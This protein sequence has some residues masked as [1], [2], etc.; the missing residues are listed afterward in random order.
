[1]GQFNQRP[2]LISSQAS[3]LFNG[4]KF[5]I[6]LDIN[7]KSRLEGMFFEC[8][9]DHIYF[10]YF[11]SLAEKLERCPLNK[12]EEKLTQ[13]LGEH[14]SFF[15]TQFLNLPNFLLMRAFSEYTG[16]DFNIESLAG[17]V[18]DKLICRCFG[19]FESQ[20]RDYVLA[21]ESASVLDIADNLKATIG[22]GSCMDDVGEVLLRVKNQGSLASGESRLD[23]EFNSDGTRIMPM[24]LNP[25]DF[26]LKIDELKRM[27]IKEQELQR[28]QLE[29]VGIKGHNI[30]FNIEPQDNRDYILQTFKEYVESKLNL[31]LRFD[32]T[33]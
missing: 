10:P 20:I 2:F 9:S 31:S 1:M 25:S 22:C 3:T 4:E 11:N 21:N 7:N 19:V 8:P 13:W 33:V 6:F 24:G 17:D 15:K 5:C 32:F 28:Y 29:I 16:A 14:E 18:S 12:V 30:F 23:S 26:V 27:W